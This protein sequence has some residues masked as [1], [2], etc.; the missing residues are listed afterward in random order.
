MKN[1]QDVIV[2]LGGYNMKVRIL[3]SLLIVAVVV[4]PLIFGGWLIAALIS[5]IIIFG[6]IEL[7]D[8]SEHK[9]KWPI[10]IKPFAIASV[11]TLVF[12]VK[13]I[14]ISLLGILLLC[15]L[16]IPVFTDKFH[17][18]DAFLCISYV[19]TFYI[20]AY[21]FL[22]IYRLDTLLIWYIIIAT[23]ACDTAAYFCGRFLGKHKLNVRISPKKTWEGSIGGWLFSI[24]LSSLFAFYFVP[25][26]DLSQILI[27]SCI[28]AISGQIGD[29]AFSAIKRCYNIKDFSD[30]LPG[31]GGI[32]DRLDSLIFNFICFNLIMVVFIL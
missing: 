11:F 27:A 2:G 24:L 5:L 26:L 6:G 1:T 4:P 10:W 3:T 30:I 23:Y 7:L 12:F 9:G 14:N 22:N 13:D 28:L 19:T 20:I 29:L 25:I 17:A 15:F 16:S 8:L 32:I 18:K 31:H 21:A